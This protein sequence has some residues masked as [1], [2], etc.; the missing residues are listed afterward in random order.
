MLK[1]D[2][3]PLSEYGISANGEKIKIQ[4]LRVDHNYFRC[5]RT[6]DE[7]T[8]RPLAR[9]F[10]PATLPSI[11]EKMFSL[12]S[13]TGCPKKSCPLIFKIIRYIKIGEIFWTY[14]VFII[15][16][17]PAYFVGCAG[18]I[19]QF[20]KGILPKGKFLSQILIQ[21]L[22]KLLETRDPD[23][24]INSWIICKNLVIWISFRSGPKQDP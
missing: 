13:G 2:P 23:L 7:P 10:C 18:A 12:F 8:S 14:T 11:T 5:Y 19:S 20:T 3:Y 17:S 4:P 24:T 6:L 1:L 21:I 9:D 22:D 15:V 16:F